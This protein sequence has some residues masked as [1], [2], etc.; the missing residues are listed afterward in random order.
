MT[1]VL[2]SQ[3]T[4]GRCPR[5]RFRSRMRSAA[6]GAHVFGIAAQAEADPA[7][8]G[9]SWPAIEMGDEVP[10]FRRGRIEAFNRKEVAMRRILHRYEQDAEVVS[11]RSRGLHCFRNVRQNSWRDTTLRTGRRSR[12]AACRGS[13][14]C[15]NCRPSVVPISLTTPRPGA[16]TATHQIHPLA[17]RLP[18][19]RVGSG[20][21]RTSG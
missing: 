5:R 6:L 2:C 17:I 16:G 12:V 19:G 13:R 11:G 9:A 4:Q 7:Q 18:C 8:R 1:R 15:G 3:A 10:R 21:P 14:P 20:H